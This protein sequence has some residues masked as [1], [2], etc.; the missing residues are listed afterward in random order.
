MRRATLAR[1]FE[2]R[3]LPGPRPA[4]PRHR[5]LFHPVTG[6]FRRLER[7]TEHLLSTHFF[8][9]TPGLPAIYSRHLERHL[10]LVE[11][12]ITLPGL[13]RADEGLR[14]LLITDIHVGPFLEPKAL[15]RVFARL[16]SVRPDLIL[17]GGD[18]ATARLD[19]FPPA[20]AAFRTLRA[21][22]GVFAVLGN[23]DHYT[24]EPER[25]TALVEACGIPVLHNRSV[26]LGAGGA[27]PAPLRLAGIDDRHAGR[28][29]LDAALAGI[30]PGA[31]VILLS[32]NPDVLFEAAARGVG[33]VLSG[34]THG[35]QIRIPGLPVLVRMSRY[36]LDEGHYRSGGT[37][38]V[39]SRG[40]GVTGLPIRFA[41]PPEAVLLTLA[42]A[43][44]PGAMR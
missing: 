38:L 13:P 31:P 11:G 5:R 37:Q 22:R 7:R 6:W 35:G 32:H 2:M 36:R 40:L 21:P 18:L 16:L 14:I 19:E 23:H 28:P 30:P 9:R 24:G 8:P 15:G 4:V 39:V 33:L 44:D 20:A 3:H 42:G 10:T 12:T 34:H 17:L 43:V 27:T 1:A 26:P 41:C 25:L 29:D